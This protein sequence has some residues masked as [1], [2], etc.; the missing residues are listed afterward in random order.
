MPSIHD[1]FAHLPE[2]PRMNKLINAN[3]KAICALLTPIVAFAAAKA[4]LHCST[5]ACAG[6]AAGLTSVAVWIVPNSYGTG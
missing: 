6:I 2:E 3:R 1:N 4:G 5:D